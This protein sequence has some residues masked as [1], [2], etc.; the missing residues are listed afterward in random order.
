MTSAVM[1][2]TV[3][4]ES[5]LLTPVSPKSTNQILNDEQYRGEKECMEI[6]SER[7]R[8][9]V[10][11]CI[12]RGDNG[13]ASRHGPVTVQPPGWASLLPRTRLT[14][15]FNTSRWGEGGGGVENGKCPP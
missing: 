7:E 15:L 14:F 2:R 5:L 8:E 4:L 10:C 3:T 11:V 13:G 9:P 1:W 12:E 6:L